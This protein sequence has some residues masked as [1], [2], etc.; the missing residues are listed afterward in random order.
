MCNVRRLRV[1][2]PGDR[3]KPAIGVLAAWGDRVVVDI[4][5]LD[6]H[7]NPLQYC[8]SWFFLAWYLD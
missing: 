2:S 1:D 7:S 8:N 4:G 3:H 5:A 6:R